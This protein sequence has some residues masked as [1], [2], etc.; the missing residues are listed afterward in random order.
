MLETATQTRVRKRLAPAYMASKRS[1]KPREYLVHYPRMARNAGSVR[2]FRR[3]S[4][5]GPSC[6]SCCTQSE[7]TTA[8]A[9]RFRPNPN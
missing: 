1:D 5:S 2:R 4:R 6:C 8:P 3:R 9:K 7:R